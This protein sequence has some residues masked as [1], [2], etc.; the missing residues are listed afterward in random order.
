MNRP[1]KYD[2]KGQKLYEDLLYPQIHLTLGDHVE[3][4]LAGPVRNPCDEPD[5]VAKI[6]KA[7]LD[8]LTDSQRSR[9]AEALGMQEVQDD[10]S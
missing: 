9:V 4:D 2:A 3:A 1:Q 8:V 6:L 5:H 10:K 7:V